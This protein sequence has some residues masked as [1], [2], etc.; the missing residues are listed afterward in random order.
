[1][2][3]QSLVGRTVEWEASGKGRGRLLRGVVVMEIP[4]GVSNAEALEQLKQERPDLIY[5]TGYY[6]F[7][8]DTHRTERCFVLVEVPSKRRFR[9]AQHIYAP[10]RAELRV[11]E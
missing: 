1:M 2:G 11:V 5:R 9:P 3:E 8:M 7:A 4:A 6:R 10:N